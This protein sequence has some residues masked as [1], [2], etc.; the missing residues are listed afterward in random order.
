MKTALAKHAPSWLAQMPSLWSRS[1]RSALE[2]RGRATRERMLRELTQAVEAISAESPLVLKLEDIHW[3]DASTVDWLSHVARRPE[4]ARLM[5]LAT[6]RPADAAAVAAG[7]GGI[8]S[9]LAVH[10]HCHEMALTPLKLEAIEAYLAARLGNGQQAAQ[11]REIARVLLERTGGNPLFMVSIVNE[12]AQQQDGASATPGAV[13]AIPQDVRRFI[14]RQINSLDEADRTLLTAASVIGREFAT[15]AVAAGLEMNVEQVEAASARLVRLGVFITRSGTGAWPDG[16]P[17]EL[18]AFRHDLYRELL[19]GRL[20][21]TR[22]VQNHAR[23]GAR[24]EAAWS[25]CPEAIAAEIAEHFERARQ[26][27]RAIPHLKRAA[28][29]AL[30]RSANEEAIG[31]LRRALAG[32][33]QVADEVERAK[34]EVELQVSMGAAF[35]AMRGFGAPEVQEAYARAEALCDRLGE[36]EDLFPAIWGQWM[37]RTGRSEMSELS[38]ARCEASGARGEIRRGRAEAPGPSRDVVDVVCLRRPRRCLQACRCRP[39]ALRWQGASGHGIE[40]WQSRCCL[41]CA[42]FQRDGPGACRRGTARAHR[43]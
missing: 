21:A 6:F 7:L 43:D 33:A 19:Y 37:F 5:V 25:T 3:S 38:P 11:P 12:L 22:L 14:E 35:M 23:V 18:Y 15:A 42:Q 39:C 29:K 10:G 24:L 36:R 26:L 8:T 13:G 4:F 20:S 16:T 17:T 34:L 41:L 28:A 1:D 32:L 40:L 30:R 31:H 2:A 9:E 27:A